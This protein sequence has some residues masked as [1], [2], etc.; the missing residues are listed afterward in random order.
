MNKERDGYLW[1]LTGIGAAGTLTI[2]FS[3]ASFPEQPDTDAINENAIE[4]LALIDDVATMVGQ[5]VPMSYDGGNIK[6]LY[7]E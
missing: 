3:V 6:F 1:G 4:T 7:R 5:N 2:L